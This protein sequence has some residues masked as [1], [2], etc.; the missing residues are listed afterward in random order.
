MTTENVASNSTKNFS[1]PNLQKPL[2]IFKVKNSASQNFF[3]LKNLSSS[4]PH[5]FIN[6]T[7]KALKVFN[8]F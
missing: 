7:I 8:V 1:S 6:Y 2:K 5:I 4:V 3:K